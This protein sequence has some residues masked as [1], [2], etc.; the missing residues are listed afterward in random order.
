M[1][2]MKCLILFGI[3][4]VSITVNAQKI[5][6]PQNKL[7]GLVSSITVQPY[8]SEV[9]FDEFVKGTPSQN[10]MK[11]FFDSKGQLVGEVLFR[12]YSLS[13][14]FYDYDESGNLLREEYYDKNSLKYMR[15]Y[16]YANGRLTERNVYEGRNLVSKCRYHYEGNDVHIAEYLG[17]GVRVGTGLD[18][19][20][21]R[22]YMMEYDEKHTYDEKGRIIR[23]S[24]IQ[25][26]D[27]VFHYNAQGDLLRT[28]IYYGGPKPF[29]I[30]SYEYTYDSHNNWIS[31]KMQES[32]GWDEPKKITSV[33]YL[34]RKINYK[35]T[36]AEVD[37]I[38]ERFAQ[39]KNEIEMSVL[40]KKKADSIQR[41][42]RDIL[43]IEREHKFAKYRDSI[44]KSQQSFGKLIVKVLQE[45]IE[46]TQSMGY[47]YWKAKN[48]LQTIKKVEIP[49]SNTYIFTLQDKT[50]LP[51]ITFVG[52]PIKVS[53]FF[54]E[55]Y[56]EG[57][58]LPDDV[59]YY[60]RISY[61]EDKEYIIVFTAS[62]SAY[63]NEVGFLIHSLSEDLYEVYELNGRIVKKIWENFNN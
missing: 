12:K 6:S 48:S 5:A 62:G 17:T 36:A 52:Q 30:I 34:E 33:Q 27:T 51:P 58:R 60:C 43:R 19:L 38:A 61:T 9:R 63:A 25:M 20:D 28:E 44:R 42:E 35:K 31:R 40:A 41:V 47:Y 54:E 15:T 55:Y 8:D 23:K 11:M 1:T 49:K 59:V 24:G 16:V 22:G 29:R 18:K 7:K 13:M 26:T 21:Q 39:R 37:E 57:L 46:K 50:T 14:K 56:N 32:E 4:L 2:M 53:E 3:L 45:N 10:S